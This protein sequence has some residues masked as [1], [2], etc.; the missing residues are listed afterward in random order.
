MKLNINLLLFCFIVTPIMVGCHH[1]QVN[2]IN[3]AGEWQFAI[4]SASIGQ[5]ER[6][7]DTTLSEVVTLPGTMDTNSKGIE[8]TNF[9][10]T[11]FLA[12]KYTYS[13]EAW[14]QKTV[15]I[16]D[17]W[18]DKKIELFIER[19]KPST[20]YVDGIRVDS[21]RYISTPH[22]YDLTQYLNDAKPHTLSI[23]IDNSRKALPANVFNSHSNSNHTQTCWN[24]MVGDIELRCTNK[25]NIESVKLTPNITKG[26]IKTEIAFD[27]NVFDNQS[28]YFVDVRAY[29]KYNHKIEVAQQSFPVSQSELSGVMTLDYDMGNDFK[30]WSEHTPN[31]YTCEIT[32]RCAD[33]IL[34]RTNYDVGMREFTADGMGLYNNNKRVF[35][36][37]KHDAAVFPINAY[38]SMDTKE[39][40]R[41][42][43]ICKDYGLN[44]L[45]FHSWCPPEACMEMADSL[46]IYLEIELPLW[47]TINKNDKQIVEFLQSEAIDILNNYANHPSV[48]M[49]TLGNELAGDMSKLNT[50]VQTI[51]DY[52]PELLAATGSNNRLGKFGSS[53]FDDFFVTCRV[54]EDSAYE[55]YD[56]HVRASFAYVDAYKG[57]IINNEYPSTATNFDAALKKATVPV[58]GHET[59]Q[60]QCFPNF[61]EMKKYSGVLE[62]RNYQ[63]FKDRVDQTG[64]LSQAKDFLKAS[65]V[66]QALL[67]K[68]D[69]EMNLRS[70]LISGFQLLDLQDYPGQGTALVGILDAFMDSKGSITDKEWRTFCSEV[71][72]LVE[73][74]KFCYSAGE[75]FVGN[76]LISNY[77]IGDLGGFCNWELV[78]KNN[79][80]VNKGAFNV[81][82]KESTL[83]KVGQI[84]FNMPQSAQAAQYKLKVNCDRDL[85]ANSYNIWVYPT[86]EH[87]QAEKQYKIAQH[88]DEELYK[89]LEDGNSVLLIPTRDQLQG[90]T[91]GGMF[92]TDY[93]NY[94]MFKRVSEV[95]KKEVSPGTLGFLINEQH[96]ALGGFPT[97]FHS[98]MQWFT[99]A[100]Q[101][102]PLIL[103][104]LPNLATPIVQVIDNVERNHRLALIFECC[105]GEGKL[106]VVMSDLISQHDSIESQALLQSLKQYIGS[107]DF[108]PTSSCSIDELKRA[109]TTPIYSVVNED[110]QNVSYDYS[111]K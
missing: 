101:S 47:G 99:I 12:R 8:N 44:H 7:F 6:W 35:L 79:K 95:H 57:G 56:N 29:M 58:V 16:P 55:N 37:G 65:G 91:V 78:D 36:R 86:L 21:V 49:F 111:K 43:Q 61:D 9:D 80:V 107:D 27:G 46:G 13:G 53:E 83:E 10:Q 92:T 98:D 96:K 106:L 42:L 17:N 109:F 52:R 66:F 50:V 84:R 70:D 5:Q 88:I 73:M 28:E 71:V 31:V 82:V 30:L 67:Y 104:N 51:K 2:S 34:D 60:Y 18:V 72:P 102:R 90:I 74:S 32:L 68:A 20:L 19:T 63:V 22:R 33:E 24:G 77:G 62:P 93:W 64:M 54:N 25:Q 45:R 108:T 1:K 26:T 38:A 87:I 110:L 4:D 15:M 75:E 81:D 11:N 23:V 59:G 94:K 40:R 97:E 100:S 3:L 76:A 85:D 103:D 48:V 89:S 14:Y 39:W 69:I 41:H 105:V